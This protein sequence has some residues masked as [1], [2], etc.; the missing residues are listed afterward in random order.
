MQSKRTREK[1]RVPM[2]LAAIIMR[3]I[4]DFLPGKY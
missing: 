3:L 4:V 1:I 2:P